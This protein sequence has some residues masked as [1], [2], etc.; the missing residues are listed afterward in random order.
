MELKNICYN[1]NVLKYQNSKK[2][3]VEVL[4]SYDSPVVAKVNNATYIFPDY[5][6]SRSTSKHIKTYIGYSSPEIRKEMDKPNSRFIYC[7]E[8]ESILD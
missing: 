6:Y 4:F 7:S 3:Q 8:P 1:A 2:Q 5:N